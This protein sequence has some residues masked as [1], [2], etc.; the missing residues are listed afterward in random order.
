MAAAQNALPGDALYPV[1][2][3]R[4]SAQLAVSSGADEGIKRLDFARTRLQEIRG[5][6]SRANNNAA[7]YIATLDRMDTLTQTGAT[8]IIDAVRHGAERSILSSV[9]GFTTVQEQDLVAILL[10]L[11]P[12]AQPAARDSLALLVLVN[13]TVGQVL[14]N[15]PCNPPSNP[16]IPHATQSSP[17]VQCSCDQ[18]GTSSQATGPGTGTS[19]SSQTGAGTPK[20]TSPSGPQAQPSTPIDQLPNVPGTQL[21]DQVKSLVDQLL[22]SPSPVPSVSVP[23]L[24]L[25][26]PSLSLG[27]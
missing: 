19:G 20:T 15:C 8:M 23:P 4:E 24:P 18:T 17:S 27:L 12:G 25:P 14:A 3:F 7:V 13:R 1:K 11:P 22:T 21:D 16:L 2:L 5:L 6:E 9:K 26:S 10:T